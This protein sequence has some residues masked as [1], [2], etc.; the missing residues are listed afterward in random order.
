VGVAAVAVAAG[1]AVAADRHHRAALA[2]AGADAGGR[3]RGGHLLLLIVPDGAERR[4]GFPAIAAVTCGAHPGA[5]DV[6]VV[7]GDGG[8]RR[9]ASEGLGGDDD[10]GARAAPGAQRT[11]G[12][13]VGRASARRYRDVSV[14]GGGVAQVKVEGD[15][16]SDQ[17]RHELVRRANNALVHGAEAE[18]SG[19]I[20]QGCS[21][22]GEKQGRR[23]G[24][25][26]RLDGDRKGSG[27][28]G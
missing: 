8:S 18:R 2:S 19:K 25:P 12:G 20:G 26:S 1:T 10:A 16:E 13:P 24:M 4:A 17:L 7:G 21:R 6:R 15:G 28:T 22:G 14:V 9:A 27:A 11:V 3:R 5:H 23:W